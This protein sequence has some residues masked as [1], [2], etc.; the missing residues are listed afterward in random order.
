MAKTVSLLLLTLVI[1]R[2]A[3]TKLP[4]QV[5]DYELPVLEELFADGAVITEVKSEPFEVHNFDEAEVFAGLKNKYGSTTEGAEALKA[6]YR[7]ERA[8]SQA[9]AASIAAAKTS[10]SA[11][12]V[13]AEDEEEDDQSGDLEALAGKTVAE[14][15]A[16]LDNLTDEDLHELAAIESAREKPRKGVLDAIATALGD[17]G[18]ETV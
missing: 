10:T 13:E 1:D 16:A 14:I 9:V 2:D 7:N 15:E 17:Q 4:V 18:S 12:N 11:E 8:F 5:F 3:T 6:A